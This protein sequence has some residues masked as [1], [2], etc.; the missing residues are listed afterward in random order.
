VGKYS[1]KGLCSR[2][3]KRKHGGLFI[4]ILI[5]YSHFTP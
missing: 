4:F 3:G 2:Y 1:F 5:V